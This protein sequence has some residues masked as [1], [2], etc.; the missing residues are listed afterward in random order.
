MTVKKSSFFRKHKSVVSENGTVITIRTIKTDRDGYPVMIT[1]DDPR[2]GSKTVETN[3][4]DD[5]H[6]VKEK[7]SVVDGNEKEEEITYIE[8]RDFDEQGN[9]REAR[10]F[11]RFKFPVEVLLREIEYWK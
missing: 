8:Y 5:R 11:N 2:T 6:N 4:L 10:T 7:H 1:T 3:I 9:W